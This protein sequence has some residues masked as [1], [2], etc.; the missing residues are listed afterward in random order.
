MVQHAAEI[1]GSVLSGFIQC[2][3]RLD[4]AL[5]GTPVET[6]GSGGDIEILCR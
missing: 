3:L 2:R 1:A 5:S 6:A 4:E